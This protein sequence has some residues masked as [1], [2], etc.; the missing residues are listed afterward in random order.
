MNAPR[1]SLIVATDLD[2]VIGREQELP[3]H[4]PDDLRRFKALTRGHAVIMGRKTHQSIGRALPGRL[5]VVVTRDSSF[6]ASGCLLA[7]SPDDALAAAIRASGTNI[8]SE[9]IFVIGGGT[10]YAHFLPRADRV[11]RTLVHAHVEGDTT[12][13][14]LDP[15]DWNLIS[16]EA[17]AADDQHEYAF[18][19]QVLDRVRT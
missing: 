12:F 5:N 7:G 10:L 19:F 8:S 6:R 15:E 13:P 2:G 17:H 3:W 4:L 11:H 16:S 18:D 14:P 1:V 9:E